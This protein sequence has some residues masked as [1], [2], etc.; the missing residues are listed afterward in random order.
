MKKNLLLIFLLSIGSAYGE[1]SPEGI[2]SVSGKDDAKTSWKAKLVLKADDKDNYPPEKFKGYFDWVGNNGM[3][4]REY[5][6]QG[7]FDYDTRTLKLMGTELEDAHPG[8]KTSLY[9]IEM[10]RDATRLENGFWRSCGVVPGEWEATR[11][12]EIE[13]KSENKSKNKPTRKIDIPKENCE[14]G[15]CK[16]PERS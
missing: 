4:G 3:T 6:V 2:W 13:S 7:D 5:I 10:N 14:G 11:S 1:P 8:I 15:K 9:T 16:L 12:L